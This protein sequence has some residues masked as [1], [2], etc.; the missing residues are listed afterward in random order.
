MLEV[1]FLLFYVIAQRCYI[2][3]VVKEVIHSAAC[4]RENGMTL[5]IKPHRMGQN[6]LVRYILWYYLCF[7]YPAHNGVIRL[8]T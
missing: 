2:T 1:L 3:A 7:T 6:Q 8:K 5:C 4:G